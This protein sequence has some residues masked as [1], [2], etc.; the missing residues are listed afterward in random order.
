MYELAPDSVAGRPVVDA[1]S[2]SVMRAQLRRHESH[3]TGGTETKSLRKRLL[4]RGL[5]LSDQLEGQ[6]GSARVGLD[7]V[8]GQSV[9]HHT[10]VRRRT[11]G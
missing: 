4:S 2:G 9:G 7:L 10:V 6:L 11:G 5:G 8:R 1:L 3:A